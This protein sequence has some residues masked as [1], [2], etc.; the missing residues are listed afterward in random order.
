MLKSA[1]RLL[2]LLLAMPAF[3]FAADCSAPE[4]PTNLPDGA[5]ASKEEMLEGQ[6]TVNQ[7]ME[8]AQAY[9]ECMDTNEEEEMKEMMALEEAAR[10]KKA[11]ELNKK[12]QDRN[13]V[14]TQ[15]QRTADRFNKQ[16]DEYMARQSDSG[17]P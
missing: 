4:P 1:F 7:Y 3:A 6:K 2:P 5:V 8:E 12:R 9:V 15:M 16:L 11:E 14:V 13:A 10:K 17:G